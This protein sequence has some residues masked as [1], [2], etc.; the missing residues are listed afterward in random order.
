MERKMDLLH[1]LHDAF[2][3]REQSLDMLPELYHKYTERDSGVVVWWAQLSTNNN[4][5]LHAED[6]RKNQPRVPPNKKTFLILDAM[7]MEQKLTFPEYALLVRDI[8]SA[9]VN[10]AGAAVDPRRDFIRAQE[11]VNRLREQDTTQAAGLELLGQKA[12]P[13]WK[14]VFSSS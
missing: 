13:E 4:I 6:W 12:N 5:V 3:Q 9:A 14:A 7:F 10:D 8:V 1:G 2:M 11:L